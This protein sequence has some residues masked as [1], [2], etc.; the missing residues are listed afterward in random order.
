M[1]IKLLALYRN[2]LV[3]FFTLRSCPPTVLPCHW[4]TIQQMPHCRSSAILSIPTPHLWGPV[5]LSATRPWLLL[6]RGTLLPSAK[7]NLV[8]GFFFSFF[9]F[10]FMFNVCIQPCGLWQTSVVACTTWDLFRFSWSAPVHET[11]GCSS[12]AVGLWL[13]SPSMGPLLAQLIAFGSWDLCGLCWLPSLYGTF[14]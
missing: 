7:R 6:L 11:F 5:T 3:Y 14:G 12:S 8:A 4:Q 2:A 9:F 1:Q 13:P 10:L